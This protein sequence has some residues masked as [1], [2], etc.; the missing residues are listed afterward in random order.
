MSW[1]DY[2]AGQILGELETLGQK[3]DTVVALVGDHGWQLVRP[4][5]VRIITTVSFWESQ[6]SCQPCHS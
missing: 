5:P 3:E 6:K 1:I 2:L 4:C